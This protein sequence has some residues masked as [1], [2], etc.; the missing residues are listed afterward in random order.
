VTDPS[1]KD[2]LKTLE[3]VFLMD[4]QLNAKTLERVG[5]R[6]WLRFNHGA[7]PLVFQW[8]RRLQQLFLQ[9]FNPQS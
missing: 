7:C 5:G 6:A 8:Q 9:Q 2:G 4:L 1:D 3:P